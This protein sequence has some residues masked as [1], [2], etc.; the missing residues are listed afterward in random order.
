M[1]LD[2]AERDDTGG[3]SCMHVSYDVVPGRLD[4]QFNDDGGPAFGLVEKKPLKRKVPTVSV[5]ASSDSYMV[6]LWHLTIDA[7]CDSA[8]RESP[9]EPY[10][11]ARPLSAAAAA[12]MTRICSSGY[13]GTMTL[14]RTSRQLGFGSMRT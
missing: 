2:K 11:R 12:A 1:E 13:W 5:E 3:P 7:P 9:V 4:I 14:S 6:E 8:P 10:K